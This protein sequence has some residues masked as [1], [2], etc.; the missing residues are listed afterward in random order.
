MSKKKKLAAQKT[1]SQP[2]L[3]APGFT[4]QFLHRSITIRI[5]H[6][7]GAHLDELCERVQ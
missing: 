4:G 6:Q 1:V 5:N 7:E 3:S 2:A